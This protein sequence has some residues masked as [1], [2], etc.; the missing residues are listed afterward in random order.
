MIKKSDNLTCAS[1]EHPSF[2]VYD[3][4]ALLIS[5]DDINMKNI[6]TLE[7]VL[8]YIDT[9]LDEP[10]SVEVLAK[11]AGY[12]PYHFSRVFSWG[13]GVSAMDYVRK[14]KLNIATYYLSTS[15]RIVDI[16]IALGF[17]THSGFSKAFKRH[18][19]CSP[20]IY[21]DHAHATYPAIP[22][23]SALNTYTIGG[24]IMNPR[25]INQEAFE[26]IGY[27][28]T[29]TTVDNKNNRD[30]A[31]MWQ[32]YKQSGDARKLHT[33]SFITEHS[34]FGVCLPPHEGLD[35]FDYLIGLKYEGHD[36]QNDYVTITIPKATYAIFTVPTSTPD[37]FTQNIQG[38]WNYI[39]NEWFPSSGYEF[40]NKGIDYEYYSLSDI[41]DE[42]LSC[43]IYLPVKK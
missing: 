23:I 26:L 30:I 31:A 1:L 8:N 41:N 3:M 32:T 2:I 24:I 43:D 20:E 10:L 6:E 33:E 22:S 42:S 39:F 11:E 25:I 17:E 5:K 36:I 15:M 9:H 13:L 19:K 18:Y 16:A 38:T 7:H 14:R 28:I 35:S 4:I 27:K 40:D 34:E 21:R 29:T 12:S 37:N